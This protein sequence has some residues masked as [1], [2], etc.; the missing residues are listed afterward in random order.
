ME[1][2]HVPR[3]QNK[4]ADALATISSMIQHPDQSYINPLEISL[5][6]HPTHCAQVEAEPDGKP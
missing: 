6:E 5:K 3:I 1:F 4:F 2:K